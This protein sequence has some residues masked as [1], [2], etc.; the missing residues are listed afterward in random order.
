MAEGFAARPQNLEGVSARFWLSRL[1]EERARRAATR[2]LALFALAGFALTLIFMIAAGRGSG[3]W[4]FL[5]AVWMGL[6]FLPLWLLTQAF[7]SIGPALRRGLTADLAGRADRYRHPSNVTL[8]VEDS[9]ERVVLMPRISRPEEAQKAREAVSALVARAGRGTSPGGVAPALRLCLA[10]LEGW[11][12][13]LSRWAAADAADDIQARWAQVRAL[14]ALAA[15]AKTL[16]AILEDQAPTPRPALGLWGPGAPG[17]SFPAAH[18]FLDAVLDYCDELALE[19][20]VFPWTEPPLGLG[21]SPRAGESPTSAAGETVREAWQRYIDTPPP[22][23]NALEGFI[24][25]TLHG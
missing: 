12:R 5:L 19:V 2:W 21:A 25:V 18:A 3:R 8:V 1:A 10:T 4:F 20:E 6:V 9:F 23:P 15:L 11:T 24:A 22:A 7:Q 17:L 14:A 13:D 16:L